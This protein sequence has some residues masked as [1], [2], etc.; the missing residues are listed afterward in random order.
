MST[1]PA[2]SFSPDYGV[3]RGRFLRAAEQ[4]GAQLSA[5]P[6]EPHGPHGEEL[7][8]DVAYIG[9]R[10]PEALLVVSSGLHGV[11]GFAGSAVQHQLLTAQLDGLALPGAVCLLLV[12]ALNPFGTYD[13]TRVFRAMRADNYL[14]HHGDAESENGRAIKA[15]LLEVFRPADPAW[16]RAVL[17]GGARV[18][19]QARNGLAA[20]S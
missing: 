18:I 5:Y 9:P 15:E 20:D 16:Q 17:A 14:Q 6:I 12:H 4:R 1:D 8:V 3:A 10:D 11:E 13:L 19:G 7:C 2:D